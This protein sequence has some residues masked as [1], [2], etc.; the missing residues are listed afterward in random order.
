M[1][2]IKLMFYT[3]WNE[4]TPAQNRAKRNFARQLAAN[5]RRM[6]AKRVVR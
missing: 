5:C 6:E 1:A 4:D 3:N 2:S